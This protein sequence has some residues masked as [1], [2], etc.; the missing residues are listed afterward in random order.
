M[1]IVNSILKLP[2]KLSLKYRKIATLPLNF[3]WSIRILKN[4]FL[5]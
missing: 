1:E 2:L 4:Y 3:L 5:H